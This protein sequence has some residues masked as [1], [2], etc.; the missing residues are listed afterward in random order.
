MISRERALDVAGQRLELWRGLHHVR[1]RLDPRHQVGLL[2]HV[3]ADAHPL[4]RL[5][6][7]PH[8]PVGNL[9]HAGDDADDADLIER[10]RA[11]LVELRVA[12]G[13]HDQG[14]LAAEHVVDQPHRA[15]LPDRQRGQRVGVGDRIL[16]R[17]HR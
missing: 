11:G 16:Q 14:A 9:E 12:G 1:E 15:L 13:D 8:R 5:D 3:V 6:E 4:R 17:Q 7:D 10:V 2:G